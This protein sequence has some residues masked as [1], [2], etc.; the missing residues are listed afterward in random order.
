MLF[1]PGDGGWRG[2]AITF[3]QTIAGWGYDVYGFDTKHYL[4][5]FSEDGSGL[6]ESQMRQDLQVAISWIRSRGA[7]QVTLVGWSQGAGMAVLT[8]AGSQDKAGIAGVVTLGLPESA[9]LAWNWKD[10]LATLARREPDEPHFKNLRIFPTT[11]FSIILATSSQR[12]VARMERSEIR[13]RN[14]GPDK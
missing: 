8:A 13:Q 4:V 9:V 7:K 11:I 5:S 12:S 3:A 10:T 6:T 14:I 1:L 2:L